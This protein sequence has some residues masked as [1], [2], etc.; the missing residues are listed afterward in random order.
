MVMRIA[1][2][3]VFE[4]LEEAT[5]IYF[6]A[7]NTFQN[8]PTDFTNIIDEGGGMI[9]SRLRNFQPTLGWWDGDRGTT[10]TDRQREEVKGIDNLGHQKVGDTFEYSFD[11]R[12]NPGFT[13]TSHFCHLFQLKATDGNSGPPLVTVS[14]YKNGSAIQGRVINS[15]DGGANTPRTFSYTAGEWAHFV[16]RITT[17]AAG[18]A[19]VGFT[20]TRYSGVLRMPPADIGSARNSPVRSGSATR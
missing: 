10:N 7:T 13:A 20:S 16:V 11:L 18:P 17:C 2:P 15:S 12:T 1:K 3:N 9:R 8:D 19:S 4:G 14:L 5:V 6:P